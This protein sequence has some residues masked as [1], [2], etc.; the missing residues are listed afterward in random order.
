MA[1]FYPRPPRGGRPVHRFADEHTDHISIHVP[2][3]G[4]DAGKA[5]SCNQALNFYPRPPRGGRPPGRYMGLYRVIFLSTSPARGTTCKR[6]SA[7]CKSRISIHVP[8][9]GDDSCVPAGVRAG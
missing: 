8:R 7:T 9:E 1:N 6:A 5:I 3:E 4:D 2:R